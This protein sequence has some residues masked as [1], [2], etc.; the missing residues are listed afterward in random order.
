MENP[1]IEVLEQGQKSD[2]KID[3]LYTLLQSIASSKY[4]EKEWF[5]KED[6]AEY[7]SISVS[8]VTKLAEK[9]VLTKY[10]L[11]S[12]CRFNRK[13]VD[14]ALKTYKKHEREDPYFG[15]RKSA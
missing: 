10:K 7:L 5:T 2:Q 11:E 15:K 9:G 3:A 6:V 1:F 8:Q 13:E 14:A 4:R 12:S